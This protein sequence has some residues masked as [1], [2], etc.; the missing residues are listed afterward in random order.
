MK[1]FKNIGN[2][3]YLNSGLQM[4]IQNK[5]LTNLILKYSSQSDTLEKIGEF[6]KEYHNP[7][8]S[9]LTPIEIKKIV[10]KKYGQFMGLE[11]QDSTE[12][13][14][15]LLDIIDDEIKLIDKESGGIESIF[16]IDINVRL[17]CKFRN[18]LK[19]SDNIEKNNILML[20]IDSQCTS[21]EDAYRAFKSGEKLENDDKYYCENCKEK[22]VASKR[23]TISSWPHDIFIWLKRFKQDG[24]KYFKNSQKLEI[25]LKWRH[26]N[27]LQGAVIH[28]GSL[29]GG[30]YVYLGKNANKWYLFDDSKI[31]EIKTD[32]EL[33][34]LLSGAYW[35]YYK[36]T[37]V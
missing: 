26:D 6:V 37:S 31:S 20:D 35:L 34:D 12:F 11:Q 29:N 22:R 17:K 32:T 27:I 24:R 14:I 8:N 4:L 9:I 18:C 21:L 7:G 16:G 10:G 2:T 36:N 19:I 1:G 25:P 3:C 13:V 28:Y 15:Q 23:H 30:H 33:S 5:K